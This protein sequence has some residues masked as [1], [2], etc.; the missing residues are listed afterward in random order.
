MFCASRRLLKKSQISHINVAEV[1]NNVP[2]GATSE[3]WFRKIAKNADTLESIAKLEKRIE[4]DSKKTNLDPE[5]KTVDKQKFSEK[6]SSKPV[7]KKY[8][9]LKVL[10]RPPA[11][12]KKDKKNGKTEINTGGRFVCTAPLSHFTNVKLVDFRKY[13]EFQERTKE[14]FTDIKYVKMITGKGGDGGIRFEPSATLKGPA[15]G[16]DGGK[17]GNIYV[18][19]DP[20][21]TTLGGIQSVYCTQSGAGGSGNQCDGKSGEDILIKV[22]VGTHIRLAIDPGYIRKLMFDNHINIKNE[23][24]LRKALDAYKVEMKCL[25]HEMLSIEPEYFMLHRDKSLINDTWKFQ[26]GLN[27]ENNTEEIH[28]I[29]PRFQSLRSK[30]RAYDHRLSVNELTNDKFPIMGLDFNKPLDNPL[31]LLKGGSAGLGN[32]HFKINSVNNPVFAKKGRNG[33][34]ASFIF[35][36]KLLA[37]LGLVGFPN[38]GKSTILRA[39][40]NA[41]PRVGHWEFTTLVPTLG[42]VVMPPGQSSYTVSDIPGIIE[43]ASENKGL[44]LEFLKHI[45]RSS[46]IVFVLG[47]DKKDPLNELKVLVKELKTHGIEHVD[48]AVIVCNKCDINDDS[49]NVQEKYKIIEDYIKIKNKEILDQK[50]EKNKKKS[51]EN[52]EEINDKDVFWDIVPISAKN[53]QNIDVLKNK[54]FKLVFDEGNNK[55]KTIID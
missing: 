47:M 46:G 53:N 39:I 7:K 22:P 25:P 43:G 19:A 42:T 48:R 24:E 34:T 41:R 3:L 18:Q 29:E 5:I 23:N 33:I 31:L 44:G 54:L 10:S 16:G 51:I 35:E 50:I 1:S 40:S 49:L 30:F 13:Q 11:L 52:Q 9:M 37:D 55:R 14:S 26:D 27:Y 6:I 32:M 36:L 38:A 12:T 45:E 17:G 2:T 15:C 28:R 20:E 4:E 8:E 21:T